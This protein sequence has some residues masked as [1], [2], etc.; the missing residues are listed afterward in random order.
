M[1]LMAQAKSFLGEAPDTF[2]AQSAGI[3]FS[4]ELLGMVKGFTGGIQD[5]VVQAL[6]GVA[7]VK[8]GPK[9]HP[10]VGEFGTGV[11][12]QLA[13]NLISGGLRGGGMAVLGQRGGGGIFGGEA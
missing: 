13:A 9:A 4:D 8:F 1:P 2:L 11:L 6:A 3:A 5:E 12:K 10:L 7:L